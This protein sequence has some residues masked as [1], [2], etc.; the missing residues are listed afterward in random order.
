MPRYKNILRRRLALRFGTIYDL[1]RSMPDVVAIRGHDAPL[2]ERVV[3]P[4]ISSKPPVD[5]RRYLDEPEAPRA[6]SDGVPHSA[7]PPRVADV[8]C[9]VPEEATEVDADG[10]RRV[11]PEFLALRTIVGQCVA[12]FP[13]GVF[14]GRFRAAFL[15]CA[16]VESKVP[17]DAC[18]LWG[19]AISG[20]YG[21]TGLRQ[22]STHFVIH[23]KPQP[24]PSRL[25][26]NEGCA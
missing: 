4:A 12:L 13:H 1:L 3:L 21:V 20:P 24:L 25:K 6:P 23:R 9:L 2:A 18:V 16:G 17:V 14:Y 7:A 22:P 26:H 15:E 10:V 11:R 8:S 5:L 19:P